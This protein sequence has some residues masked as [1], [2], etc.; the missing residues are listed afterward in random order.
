MQ[1]ESEDRQEESQQK[2]R[3]IDGM[4]GKRGDS[5]KDGTG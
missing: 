3:E 5:E 4:K 2:R 1:E